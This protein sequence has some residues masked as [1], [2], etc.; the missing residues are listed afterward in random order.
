[1]PD[2]AIVVAQ[3]VSTRRLTKPDDRMVNPRGVYQYRATSD[4]KALDAFHASV[5][6]GCL[7]DFVITV[8]R[9]TPG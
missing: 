1:M 8:T 6:I 5:P 3:R 2:F 4:A 9:L 7:D